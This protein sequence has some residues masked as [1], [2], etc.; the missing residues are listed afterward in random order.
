MFVS[1]R[2]GAAPAAASA[3]AAPPKQ[4]FELEMQ[5]RMMAKK[6]TGK[7]AVGAVRNF[8]REIALASD[9]ILGLRQQVN[10]LSQFAGGEMIF[11]NSFMTEAAAAVVPTQSSMSEKEMQ[12][13]VAAWFTLV[14]ES[15]GGSTPE[16]P[17]L[18][19]AGKES[20][21]RQDLLYLHAF[22]SADIAIISKEGKAKIT[23]E[24]NR[25]FQQSVGKPQP[26][27]PGEWA[28]SYIAYGSW[29]R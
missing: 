24:V 13:A 22:L 27:T 23:T 7:P 28:S 8:E 14:Y 29:T 18:Q 2:A 10:L 25:L 1:S 9:R 19:H 4:D 11:R 17:L 20:R 12:K 5:M 15:P 6:D 3:E 16:H 26:S 21:P